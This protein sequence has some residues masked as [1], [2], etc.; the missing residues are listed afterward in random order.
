[1]LPKDTSKTSLSLPN[2]AIGQALARTNGCSPFGGKPKTAHGLD[3]ISTQHVSAMHL[4]TV[5]QVLPRRGGVIH[6]SN[7]IDK[8][9]RDVSGCWALLVQ[10]ARSKARQESRYHRNCRCCWSGLLRTKTCTAHR[11]VPLSVRGPLPVSYFTIILPRVN[12]SH[13][14]LACVFSLS[15]SGLSTTEWT[16]QLTRKIGS[17]FTSRAI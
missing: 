13:I 3:D 11:F 14:N 9:I 2:L 5:Q 16:V 1:M 8:G 12:H 15:I 10:S 4:Y 6:I 7:P 17:G